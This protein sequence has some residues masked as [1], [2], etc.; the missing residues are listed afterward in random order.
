MITNSFG[1][2]WTLINTRLIGDD[3]SASV[4]IYTNTLFF[5][6]CIFLVICLNAVHYC[7]LRMGN[8]IGGR[9]P[10]WSHACFFSVQY[11]ISP[12]TKRLKYQELE[13]YTKEKEC[14]FSDERK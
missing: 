14:F 7:C 1:M 13:L 8:S 9:K 5:I 2:E 11:T 12:R 3:A 4:Y 10:F 6:L